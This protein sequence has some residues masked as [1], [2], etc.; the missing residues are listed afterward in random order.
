MK[1]LLK[2]L[3]PEN[4]NETGMFKE[5]YWLMPVAL[6]IEKYGLDDFET[7]INAISEITKRN[8]GEYAIRPFISFLDGDRRSPALI[9][10]I[11]SDFLH[12][13]NHALH[14]I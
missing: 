10:T 4:E 7:S 8:T 2:I 14:C 9:R 1:I 13:E 5:Y 6:F 12:C 3:G 11:R